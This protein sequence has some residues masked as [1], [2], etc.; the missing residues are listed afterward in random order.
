MSVDSELEALRRRRL[1]A[2]SAGVA[3]P[4]VKT[5]RK[6]KRKHEGCPECM[7]MRHETRIAMAVQSEWKARGILG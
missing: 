4:T 3:K 2:L 1:E 5:H 6:S 7:H